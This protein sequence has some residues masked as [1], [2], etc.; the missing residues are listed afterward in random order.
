MFPSQMR[1]CVG[2]RGLCVDPSCFSNGEDIWKKVEEAANFLSSSRRGLL[3][4]CKIRTK[5]IKT[6]QRLWISMV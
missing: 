5:A 4:E 3:V 6:E 1:V 2:A